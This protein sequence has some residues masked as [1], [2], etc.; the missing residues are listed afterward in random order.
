MACAFS[1][2][3]DSPSGNGAFCIGAAAAPVVTRRVMRSRRFGITAL[4]GLFR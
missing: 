3:F 1:S 4:I 2:A